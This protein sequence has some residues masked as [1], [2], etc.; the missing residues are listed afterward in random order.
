MNKWGTTLFFLIITA[1]IFPSAA[2]AHTKLSSSTPKQDETV[3]SAIQQIQMEFN[4]TIEPLS[5]FKL[6]GDVGAID[7]KELKID[8]NIMTGSLNNDL[9][10][11][12]YKVEWKIVG[13]DGHPIEGDFSFT[14]N[15]QTEST[16]EPKEDQISEPIQ[17]TADNT[18]S[19]GNKSVELDEKVNAEATNDN[20]DTEASSGSS[21]ELLYI[22]IVGIAIILIG[23]VAWRKKRS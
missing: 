4:T 17:E 7:M 10:N 2:S 1:L 15:V 12:V 20:N 19:S 8:G 16:T 13:K 9:E 18:E 23:F 6:T 22:A 3:T 11:G 14:V 5:S 21:T